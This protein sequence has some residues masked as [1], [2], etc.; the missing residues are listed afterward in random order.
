MTV[1]ASMRRRAE[2]AAKKQ[3]EGRP[4]TDEERQLMEQVAKVDAEEAAAQEEERRAKEAAERLAEEAAERQVRERATK[5]EADRIARERAAKAR[6]EDDDD[7][8]IVPRTLDKDE[9]RHLEKDFG[10]DLGRCLENITD[11]QKR[12]QDGALVLPS[13]PAVPAARRAARDVERH[14]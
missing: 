14:G 12:A 5:E 9:R 10:R 6:D 8:R 13:P 11:E 3:S 4:L 7:V 2:A 1:S